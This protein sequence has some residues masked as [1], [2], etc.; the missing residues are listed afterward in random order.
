MNAFKSLAMGNLADFNPWL[1]LLVLFAG[2]IVAFALALFLFE[3]DSHNKMRRSPP[4]LALLAL[5]PY[6]LSMIFS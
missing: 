2:G 6:L 4:I 3:W 5:A 1:S